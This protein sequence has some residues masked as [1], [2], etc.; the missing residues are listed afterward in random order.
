VAWQAWQETL[1]EASVRY[2]VSASLASDLHP[3][4]RVCDGELQ[5]TPV[6]STVDYSVASPAICGSLN[7]VS[8]FNDLAST[9][10]SLTVRPRL[11]QCT[12]II[13]IMFCDVWLSS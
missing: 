9:N 12:E 10:L 6:Y 8:C 4:L 2:D 7:G 11:I 5:V 1:G 3:K 13:F